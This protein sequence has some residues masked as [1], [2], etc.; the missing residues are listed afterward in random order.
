MHKE[1]VFHLSDR[2]WAKIAPL[3]PQRQLSPKGGRPPIS[4]RRCFE[5]ILWILRTG[6]QWSEL[7]KT[8]GSGS[9]CWRRLREWEENGILL[10][11]WR[12]FLADLNDREKLSWDRCFVDGSFA[13]AKKGA[14][15]SEKPRRERVQSGW[16]WSMARVLRWEHDYRRLPPRKSA[17]LRGSN[18]KSQARRIV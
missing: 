9:T 14:A 13:P 17:L 7:P 15:K 2:K 5:G 6:A 12:V 11:L 1:K 10:K 8:Y 16:F 4:D 18:R 3:L